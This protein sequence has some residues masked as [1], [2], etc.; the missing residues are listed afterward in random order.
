LNLGM[1]SLGSVALL[2]LGDWLTHLGAAR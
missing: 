2:L 1:C